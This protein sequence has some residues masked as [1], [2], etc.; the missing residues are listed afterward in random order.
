MAFRKAIP[1]SLNSN[2]LFWLP[3]R[4]EQRNQFPKYGNAPVFANTRPHLRQDA[5]DY[6]IEA[7]LLD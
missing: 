2:S 5:A 7:G 4:P 3:L 6:V 1:E